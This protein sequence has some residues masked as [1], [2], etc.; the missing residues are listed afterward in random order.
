MTVFVVSDS[1]IDVIYK[2]SLI[3]YLEVWLSPFLRLLVTNRIC[4]FFVIRI[5]RF[6]FMNFICHYYWGISQFKFVSKILIPSLKLTWH[7]KIHPWKRRFLLETIIFGCYVSFQGGYILLVEG[8]RTQCDK[9]VQNNLWNHHGSALVQYFS[10]QHLEGLP[11]PDIFCMYIYI[12]VFPK[13]GVLQN[14]WFMMENPTKMDVLVV[15]LFLET[16]IY[17]YTP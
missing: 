14:G 12:W 6:L 17:T 13:I 8:E 9:P 11:S 3:F 2:Q 15:P 16:P 10:Q 5:R 7:L 1:Y 4:S